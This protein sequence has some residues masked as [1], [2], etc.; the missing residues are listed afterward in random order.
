MEKVK[1]PFD[2]KIS[3]LQGPQ[4][5]RE[6]L[7]KLAEQLMQNQ[8]EFRYS[9]ENRLF[10]LFDRSST[11]SV[12]FLKRNEVIILREIMTML[13]NPKEYWF[14]LKIGEQNIFTCVILIPETKY[15]KIF[16]QTEHSLGEGLR[17]KEKAEFAHK[18]LTHITWVSDGKIEPC[19]NPKEH[20][21]DGY[22]YLPADCLVD[23]DR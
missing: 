7:R 8:G 16:E 12:D 4:W 20:G 11:S 21:I 19:E 10:I 9:L 2:L 6:N 1:I 22:I 18:I 14:N 13:Q 17:E 15:I 5:E 3:K 23:R